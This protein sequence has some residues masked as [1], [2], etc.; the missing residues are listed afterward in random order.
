MRRTVVS[1]TLVLLL[2]A[3]G[4]F[5]Q[6]ANPTGAGLVPDHV[7]LTWT[8]DPRTTQTVTWRADASVTAGVVQYQKG[9]TLSSPVSVKALRQIFTTDQGAVSLFTATLTGLD[10]GATY[11]YR[12]GDGTNWNPR[13]PSPRRPR[14]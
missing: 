5:G 2:V 7:T 12:V 11:A 6:S 13:S 10:S 9:R 4:L 1:I 8:G 14:A 3:A